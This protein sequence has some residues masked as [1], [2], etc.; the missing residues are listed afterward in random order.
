MKIA[1]CFYGLPRLIEE[2]HNDIKKY[3]IENNEVNVYAHFWWDN[4]YCDKINRLHV[5]EKYS[6]DYEPINIFN[7]LYKPKKITFEE[8]PEYNLKNSIK[9]SGWNKNNSNDEEEE[10]YKIIGNFTKYSFYCRYLSQFKSYSLIDSDINYD[11]VILLRTDLTLFR[12]ESSLLTDLKYT[13]LD[14]QVYFASSLHGGPQFGGEH[15]NR[16]CDWFEIVNYKN[17]KKY[18]EI[19]YQIFHTNINIIPIHNQ[20]RLYFICNMAGLQPKIFNSGITIRRYIIEEWE[21]KS[22]LIK[23]KIN[24]D[25]YVKIFY[26]NGKINNMEDIINS[27]L[28]PFYTKYMFDWIL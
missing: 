10:Y 19:K 28:L 2:C 20:E 16:A 6:S 7:K 23:N 15:P 11:M 8:C 27:N 25:D 4:D 14:E 21:D 3:F 26:N 5:K 9:I 22:Y 17:I 1:L 24:P 18:M 12:K 13:N